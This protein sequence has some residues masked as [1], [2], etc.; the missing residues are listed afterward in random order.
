MAYNPD[1]VS[2]VWLRTDDNCYEEFQ[3][4]ET[5]HGGQ[6]LDQ[7][8]ET[9]KGKDAIVKNEYEEALQSKIRLMPFIENAADHAEPSA[10][11]TIKGIRD[12][13]KT[14]KRRSHKNI[15]EVI[16]NG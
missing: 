3:I 6:T 11:A 14:E 1:D 9:R 8:M 7:V 2:S 16:N 5:A 13:R 10:D 15:G 4:I 12:N